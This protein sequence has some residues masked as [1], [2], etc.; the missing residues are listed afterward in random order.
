VARLLL[1]VLINQ[2]AQ[3]KVQLLQARRQLA[4]LEQQKQQKQQ[5]QAVK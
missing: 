3:H 2:L 4:Q 1:Q 5:R